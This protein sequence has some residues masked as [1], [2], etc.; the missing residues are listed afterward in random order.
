MGLPEV[1]ANGVE[2][3]RVRAPELPRREAHAVEMLAL[4]HA[5]GVLVGENV[6][7]VPLLDRADLATG[8]ARRA[9]GA[10]PTWAIPTIGTG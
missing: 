4:A 9:D 7:A 8:I 5:V 6:D 1:D 3:R 2:C 10:I